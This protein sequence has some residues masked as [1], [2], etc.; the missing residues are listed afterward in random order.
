MRDIPLNAELKA[1]SSGQILMQ[2]APV[3]YIE[4]HNTEPGLEGAQSTEL[5]INTEILS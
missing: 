1:L 5:P 2:A 3:W 4:S